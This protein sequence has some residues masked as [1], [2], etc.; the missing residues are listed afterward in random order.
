MKPTLL[1]IMKHCLCLLVVSMCE[2]VYGS[3]YWLS[4][5]LQ[6]MSAENMMQ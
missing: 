6:C 3:V 2:H 1:N 4:Q 5:W